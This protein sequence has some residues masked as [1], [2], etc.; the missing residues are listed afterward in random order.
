M[1]RDLK[2]MRAVSHGYLEGH[3]GCKAQ[4]LRRLCGQGTPGVL[5]ETTAAGTKAVGTARAQAFPL[6]AEGS[7]ETGRVLSPALTGS[8]FI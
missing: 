1:R 3:S 4:D 2:E 5:T 8:H 7:T 6:K